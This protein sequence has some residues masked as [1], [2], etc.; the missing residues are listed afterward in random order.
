MKFLHW[1]IPGNQGAVIRVVLD[2]PA[3]VRLLDP[4]AYEQYKR[5]SKFEGLGG[6]SDKL[7]I[8]FIYPY[9]GIFHV[10]VDM[11]GAAGEV[12]ATCEVIRK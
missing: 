7:E 6:W 5:G 1:Q 2:S 12:K 9:K 3:Y 10:T 11:G 8:E 4:L